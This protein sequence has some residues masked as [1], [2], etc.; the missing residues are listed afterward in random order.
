MRHLFCFNGKSV[1]VL[2]FIFFWI[3]FSSD[4]YIAD[5]IAFPFFLD[6]NNIEKLVKCTGN[7]ETPTEQLLH[8]AEID[9]EH[10]RKETLS[11]CKVPTIKSDGNNSRYNSKE[12]MTAT[13]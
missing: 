9:K 13:L 4:D 12:Q 1:V 8:D 11:K 6:E 5:D 10:S 2:L 7:T 3:P